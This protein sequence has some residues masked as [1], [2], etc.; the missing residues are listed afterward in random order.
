MSGQLAPHSLHP[1]SGGKSSPPLPQAVRARWSCPV[2]L[3]HWVKSRRPQLKVR[4]GT[5]RSSLSLGASRAIVRARV[6]VPATLVRPGQRGWALL[7]QPSPRS[8]RVSPSNPPRSG[9]APARPAAPPWT[10]KNNGLGRQIGVPWGLDTYL[11]NS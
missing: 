5:G 8:L 6:A 10:A 2:D 11:F 1:K 9:G 3:S 7:F 4:S